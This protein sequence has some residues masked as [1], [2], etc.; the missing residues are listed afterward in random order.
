MKP[1]RTGRYLTCDLELTCWDGAP[2]AGMSPEI[3]EI[4]ICEVNASDMSI[5]SSFAWFVKP[6]RSE[7]S[8]YC[9][10]LTGVSREEVLKRGRPLAEVLNAIVNAYAPKN[11]TLMTWGDDHRAIEV[12]CAALGIGNPFPAANVI[13]MGQAYNLA[14]GMDRRIGL[15]EAMLQLGLSVSGKTHRAEAD[16]VDT[17]QMAIALAR[18]QRAGVEAA[19]KPQPTD[20]DP[21]ALTD[22]KLT[23]MCGTLREQ[24]RLLEFRLAKSAIPE[25]GWELAP[26]LSDA[27]LKLA[28]ATEILRLR[29]AAGQ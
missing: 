10:A 19:S 9:E 17:A 8:P 21:G 29:Q 24:V 26:V 4:G 16:A 7:I 3:F 12:D 5:V 22:D 15:Q 25:D 14:A 13:N 6:V 20:A 11:K 2:P 1:L 28:M 27:R 18:L 23:R